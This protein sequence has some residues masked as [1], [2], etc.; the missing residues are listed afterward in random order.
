[1]S[2]IGI[3]CIE[4][5]NWV[6]NLTQRT[7]IQPALGLLNAV[8]AYFEG[9][10]FDPCVVQ[11][12]QWADGTPAYNVY[13]DADQTQVNDVTEDEIAGSSDK[14]PT[15]NEEWQRPEYRRG[16]IVTVLYDGAQYDPCLV[17]EVVTKRGV[18]TSMLTRPALES[19]PSRTS[20]VAQKNV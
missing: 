20:Q 3:F 16:D 9:V 13:F 6:E 8:R 7:S 2:G 10:L 15:N 14:K 19:S 12:L 4:T 1:M 11:E 17:E 5:G 18:P